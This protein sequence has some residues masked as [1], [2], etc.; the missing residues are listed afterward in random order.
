MQEHA[1]TSTLIEN[2]LGLLVAC[3]L[4]AGTQSYPE[5][6]MAVFGWRFEGCC[7]RWR[8]DRLQGTKPSR[9]SV[10]VKMKSHWRSSANV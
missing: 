6:P 2:S 8:R 10:N 5:V 9:K 3:A 1:T 4:Y 7:R